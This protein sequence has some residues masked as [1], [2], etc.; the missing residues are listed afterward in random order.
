MACTKRVFLC[1]TASCQARARDLLFGL[2]QRVGMI[3]TN[4]NHEVTKV[5]DNQDQAE[6]LLRKLTEVLP[7]SA[8][9][10]PPLRRLR[11]ITAT[12]SAGVA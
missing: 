4:P 2:A 3:R 7:L 12:I 6:R 11:T 9:A 10:T 1:I 8:L 5:I